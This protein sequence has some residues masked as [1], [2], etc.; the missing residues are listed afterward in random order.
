M[1][2]LTLYRSQAGKNAKPHALPVTGRKERG[3]STYRTLYRATPEG[4]RNL[5][6]A[7]RFAGS[8]YDGKRTPR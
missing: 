3:T 1:R 7:S 5:S 4:R 2:N 8:K 6:Q